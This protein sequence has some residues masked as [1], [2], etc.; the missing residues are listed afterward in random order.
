[1]RNRLSLQLSSCT[2]DLLAWP[3]PRFRLDP[4]VLVK[5]GFIMSAYVQQA[6]L[7]TGRQMVMVATI[8]L[9]ALVIALALTITFQRD[10]IAQTPRLIVDMLTRDTVEPPPEPQRI[11]EPD[12]ARATTPNLPQPAPEFP[13]PSRSNTE[14]TLSPDV[15][16][17]PEVPAVSG[18]TGEAVVLPAPTELR[19]QAVRPT[20]DYYPTTS[21]Q[22]QEEGVAVVRV[23][24]GADGRIAGTPTVDSS[25]G[26]RRLDNAAVAWTRE[27]LRF[28]PATREGWP[29]AA[30]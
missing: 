2:K 8:G 24:V 5:G 4:G 20:D 25:S 19:Y 6:G 7:V 27:A 26:S 17:V 18:G 10:P 9:H 29:V 23:C 16:R 28:T 11:V 13:T 14:Q 22:L 3:R 21:I 1:L 15:W 12:V 30:C